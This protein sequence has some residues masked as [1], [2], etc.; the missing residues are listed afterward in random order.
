MQPEIVSVNKIKNFMNNKN[1]TKKIIVIKNDGGYG[2]QI[3]SIVTSFVI[4]ILSERKLKIKWDEIRPYIEEPFENTFINM[5]FIQPELFSM[6]NSNSWNKVKNIE[7]SMK[8]NIS[9]NKNTLYYSDIIPAFFEIC[10]N[11]TYYSKLALLGLVKKTTIDNVLK[12]ISN[13]SNEELVENLYLI[14][15]IFNR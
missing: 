9:S 8:T 11:P 14:G 3:F 2:N 5:N 12:L 1:V 6:T 13:K 7:N 4:A 10:S 15:R